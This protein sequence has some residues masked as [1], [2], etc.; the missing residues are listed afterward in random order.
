MTHPKTLS[1]T[2]S[3]IVK[4]SDDP[5]MILSRPRYNVFSFST[6]D[7]KGF[8][9]PTIYF[10]PKEIELPVSLQNK[11]GFLNCTYQSKTETIG[12]EINIWLEKNSEHKFDRH[13]IKTQKYII[14][15][16]KEIPTSHLN[17]LQIKENTDTLEKE[18]GKTNS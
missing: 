5:E 14:V 8:T 12:A 1:M 16:S 7:S 4:N 2:Y 13:T 6:Q 3:D 18:T 9:L 11:E 17:S 10:V 15:S